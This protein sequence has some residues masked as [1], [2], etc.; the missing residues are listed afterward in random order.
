MIKISLLKME[1]SRNNEEKK[2]LV[3][4]SGINYGVINLW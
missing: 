2:C 3:N 1:G 4:V